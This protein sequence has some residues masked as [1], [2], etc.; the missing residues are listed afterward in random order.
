MCILANT[1]VVAVDDRCWPKV[2]FHHF[3]RYPKPV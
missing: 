2:F 3:E 1:L